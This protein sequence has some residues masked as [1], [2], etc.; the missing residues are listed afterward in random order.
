MGYYEG[1]KSVG[2]API[3]ITLSVVTMLGFAMLYFMCGRQTSATQDLS[4]PAQ[5]SVPQA[6]QPAQSIQPAT[7][8]KPHNHV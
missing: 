5:Q 3:L 4:A 2:L 7:S 6:V 8:A 1:E